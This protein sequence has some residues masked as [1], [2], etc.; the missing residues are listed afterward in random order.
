MFEFAEDERDWAKQNLGK[1][2]A[3]N[4]VIVTKEDKRLEANYG[5][6]Q[7]LPL[8][9]FN[10][11]LNLINTSI[12][13]FKTY[14]SAA[15]YWNNYWAPIDTLFVLIN[16]FII[17]MVMNYEP[18]QA[19][20]I[21]EAFGMILLAQ[22][23][24][25]F[26]EMHS[27]IAPLII[28]FYQVLYDILD[29]MFVI[30]IMFCAFSSAFYLLGQNQLQ[31]DEIS[32]TEGDGEEVPLYITPKKALLFMFY[33]LLGEVGPSGN[34]DKGKKTQEVALWFLFCVATFFFII[35]M[36]NMLVAIMGDTFVKNYEIEEQ[37]ILRTKL[38]FVIDNWS[39]F[40]PFTAQEKK[41]IQYLVAANLNDND[42]EETEAIREL[43]ALVINMKKKTK[44]DMRKIMIELKKIKSIQ[45][46]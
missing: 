5:Y 40:S 28:I 3:N 6:N 11:I 19:L 39:L 7:M 27:K 44:T 13:V 24:L 10:L 29:F 18:T 43:K 32:A 34:F 14:Q 45:T 17:G 36:M 16:F 22:K 33:M 41:Q 30:L 23:S 42:E 26:L 15:S 2:D 8:S 31:F 35:V 21:F 1:R 37:N 12:V 4:T 9:I 38:R 20:R 25:Y 46:N